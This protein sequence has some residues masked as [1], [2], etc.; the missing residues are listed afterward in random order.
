MVVDECRAVESR[1][2]EWCVMNDGRLVWS[3]V[4][5]VVCGVIRRERG[6]WVGHVGWG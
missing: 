4:C 6:G 1:E 2:W 5:V 3:C